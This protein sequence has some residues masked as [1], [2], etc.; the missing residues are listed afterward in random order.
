MGRGPR[1]EKGHEFYFRDPEVLL[2]YPHLVTGMAVGYMDL[3][4][5]GK[6]TSLV[7]LN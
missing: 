1:W 3:A 2:K 7:T 4:V 6:V 5:R